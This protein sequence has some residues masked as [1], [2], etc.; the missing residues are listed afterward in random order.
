MAIATTT[1]ILLARPSWH[2][3][4]Q[5]RRDHD[6]LPWRPSWFLGETTTISREDRRGFTR[7]PRRSSLETVV[8][9]EDTT[10]VS[11]GDRRD[12]LH[13]TTVFFLKTVVYMSIGSASVMARQSL[14]QS[15]CS[16]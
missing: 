11:I 14:L 10:T 12:F 13:T 2:G 16:K 15:L 3:E 5:A 7:K 1:A 6:G 9:T 8:V 4:P